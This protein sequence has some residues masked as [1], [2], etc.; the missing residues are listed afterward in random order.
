[1]GKTI[2]ENEEREGEGNNLKF[3]ITSFQNVGTKEDTNCVL[4]S[5]PKNGL[6]NWSFMGVF[7]GHYKDSNDLSDY[8]SK[9]LLNSIKNTDQET[10]LLI[11]N[12]QRSAIK[13]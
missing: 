11:K 13:R 2:L 12:P 5:L 9:E 4:L 8:L 10:T 6:E 1:M 3:G 7:D